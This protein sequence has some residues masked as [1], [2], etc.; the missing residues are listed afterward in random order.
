MKRLRPVNSCLPCRN[1]RLKCDKEHPSCGRCQ[2]TNQQCTYDQSA[3]ATAPTLDSEP[4]RSASAS[5][6]IPNPSEITQVPGR[7]S[8]SSASERGR[9][10]VSH[11]GRTSYSGVTFWGN[12]IPTQVAESDEASEGQAV[13]SALASPFLSQ[14]IDENATPYQGLFRLP[15]NSSLAVS[16]STYTNCHMCGRGYR[17]SCILAMLPD[18]STCEK[19]CLIFVGKVFSLIP[20]LHLPTF[21]VEFD[22]LWQH[23][24]SSKTCQNRQVASVLRR[25]P[26]L[27]CLL[28]SMMFSVLYCTPES[29]LKAAFGGQLP[30]LS[31]K[32][33]YL[34]L[35]VVA[36]LTGFPM[37]PTTYT[38]A[39]Y[40]YTQS[41]FAREEDFRDAPEFVSVSF[42]LAI[43]MGLHRQIREV[44][45]EAGELETRRRLWWYIIHLDVMV[46]CSSGLS[47]LF[48]DDKM[49][50]T[51]MIQAFDEFYNGTTKVMQRVED[52]RYIVAAKRYEAS[53]EMR[54]I[55][56]LHFEDAFE[57][58]RILDS[59]E[60]RLASLTDSMG[61]TCH[62]LLEMCSS[63][64]L[65]TSTY[66]D[67]SGDGVDSGFSRVWS[68]K[69][70]ESCDREA[71]N[72]ASWSVLLLHMMVHKTYCTLYHPFFSQG[73]TDDADLA[74]KLSAVR[75]A[76]AFLYLFVHLCTLPRS[77]PFHWMYPGT[78]QPLQ[79]LSLLIA[80][81]LLR[82]RSDSAE[83]SRGI[84]DRVFEMYSI[85][86]GI[87]NQNDP[88]KRNLSPGGKGAWLKLA[89]ARRKALEQIGEE[90][91]LL[92]P[93]NDQDISKCLCGQSIDIQGDEPLDMDVETHSTTGASQR[94]QQV[95]VQNTNPCS[96]PES[97][98]QNFEDPFMGSAGFDWQGFDAIA[99]PASGFMS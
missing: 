70:G 26:G 64:S 84:V 83:T 56:R 92:L 35:T 48:I 33:C 57:D 34:A 69:P 53:K 82:P 1:R 91:H 94:P 50:N 28:F 36:R 67:L 37:R 29:I 58:R 71:M 54:N 89:Q 3:V 62:S 21:R 41:Q 79:A 12:A 87:V 4:G 43:G 16:A 42:R 46:S 39:A 52:I 10:N 99:G 49:A 24:D 75:H 15:V 96:V 11:G 60:N 51:T 23:L 88:L 45:M 9:F 47:P 98:Q 6:S 27:L 76:Q 13:P 78:Y 80:D 77:E 17:F 14:Q 93:S 2:A 20:I 30:E 22:D 85:D 74:V 90:P 18:R 59:A 61:R 72:F 55:L 7:S 25:K 73:S 44:T 63:C 81:L 5:R 66:R 65:P 31:T 32:T 8:G 97:E 68:L 38:L 86:H 95:N 19:L 40:I